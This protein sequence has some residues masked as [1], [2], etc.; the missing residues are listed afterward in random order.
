MAGDNQGAYDDLLAVL[1][2]KPKEVNEV[3]CLTNIGYVAGKLGKN[4]EAIGYLKKLVE[5]YPKYL[6]GYINLAYRYNE[7]GEYDRSIAVNTKALEVDKSL[8][9]DKDNIYKASSKTSVADDGTS[10]ALIYNNRGYARYKT[11]DHEGALSDINTSISQ[12]PDNPYAY[13]NRALVYI[14]TKNNEAACKDIAKALELGF[15]EA[16]GNEVEELKKTLCSR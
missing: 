16:Y 15:T 4:E 9:K 6:P 1:N 7:V 10:E 8:K 13:R 5:K 12:K 2:N 3:L 14:A 11:G